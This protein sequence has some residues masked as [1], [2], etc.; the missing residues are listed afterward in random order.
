MRGELKSKGMTKVERR[1]RAGE[2]G[3]QLLFYGKKGGRKKRVREQPQP[4]SK[5]KEY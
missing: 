5:K 4:T 3:E 1:E 2:W